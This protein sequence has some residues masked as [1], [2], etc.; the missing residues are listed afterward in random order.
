M[1]AE[2]F[3]GQNR[4]GATEFYKRGTCPTELKHSSGHGGLD[5]VDF[6]KARTFHIVSGT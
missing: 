4:A 5:G 6:I 2:C 1:M 3:K